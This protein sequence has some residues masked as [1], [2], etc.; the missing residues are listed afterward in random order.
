MKR[1]FI[2]ITYLIFILTAKSQLIIN[3]LSQGPSGFKEYV[4]L[5]VTG[6]PVC[7]GSNT[8]DLR[9]WIIDDNN[10]WHASGAGTGIAAGHVRFDSIPLWANV[11]IGTLILIYNDADTSSATAALTIDTNDANNDCVYIVPISS[12]VLQKN[13]TLPA[14]NGTMATYSVSGTVYSS[15]GTWTI[16]GM[17]NGGDAFHTVS[18]ANYSSAYHAIGWGNVNQQLDVYF[19]SSQSGMVIYMANTVD[20]NP[21]NQLNYVDSSALTHETPGAP[22]NAANAAWIAS[23]NNNCQPFIPPVVSIN[24]PPQ[25]TCSNT[26]VI[27]TPVTNGSVFQWST[28]GTG[29]TDTVITG[30]NYQVTVTDLGGLC[31]A[32]ASVFV[33]QNTLT[34]NLSITT[35]DSIGCSGDMDTLFALSTTPGVSFD[36]G[37]GVASTQLI[38]TLAGNYSVTVTDPANGCTASE[39]VTVYSAANLTLSVSSISTTCGNNNGSVTVI[40]TSGTAQ[41]YLW[42]NGGNTTT[43][44][45]LPAGSYSV[46]VDGGSG[47]SASGGTTVGSSNSVSVITNSN[48]SIMCSGDS[49]TICATANF[50]G[51]LWNTGDTSKCIKARQAGNY[52]VTVT[53][54]SGCTAT[55][56]PVTLSVYPLPP[57]SISVNGDTLRAY[58]AVSY[59]WHLNNNPILNATSNTYIAQQAGSYTVEVTDS[60]G[61]RAIS[62]AVN[63]VTG[64]E[65]LFGL[66]EV[67]IYPNP[68]VSGTWVLNA[69]PDLIGNLFEILNTEGRILYESEIKNGVVEIN[70]DLYSGMY[71]LRIM[72]GQRIITRKLVKL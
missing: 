59:Q 53:D 62:T 71:F 25:L 57:V 36:W 41:S 30:G 27:L 64:V 14:S 67:K 29:L 37:G 65:V 19:S 16:L 12:S 8:V 66:G 11:K 35:P 24:T 56:S 21:F 47:C 51:Y 18:P 28:G 1:F 48:K 50:T 72:D 13:T 49:A 60:N 39:T 61:C 58:N 5:L 70:T 17:A 45:N 4:E 32:S 69:S 22:N 43:I 68:L 46:T 33:V 20:D 3:E 2:S 7:N 55:S 23:L 54:A 52:Y 63:L 9:G 6:T 31:S 40:V 34:P 10:S 15:S 44:T 38:I 42:S 26:E